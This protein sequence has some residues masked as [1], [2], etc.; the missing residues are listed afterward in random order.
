MS[1]TH[2]MGHAG[3]IPQFADSLFT[4]LPKFELKKKKKYIYIYIHIYLYMYVFKYFILIKIF[5]I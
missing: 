2:G 1:R 3:C 5:L 4:N